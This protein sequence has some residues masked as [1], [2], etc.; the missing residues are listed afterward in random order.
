MEITWLGHSCVRIR[1]NDVTLITDPFDESLGLS[2]GAQSADIVTVSHLHPHH[3]THA[4]IQGSPRVL[5]GPG[6]YEI[7]NYYIT[8]IGTD[9]DAPQGEQTINTMYAI[10]CEGLRLCHLG[11]LN[12]GLSSRQIDYLSQTDV[13][14]VPAGGVCTLDTARVVELINLIAPRIVVPLH[15]RSDGVLVELQPLGPFLEAMGDARAASSARLTV[16]ATSLPRDL[17]LAVLDRSP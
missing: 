7:A 4:G 16:T 14:F 13:L 5:I 6:E 1:S 11:D 17:Q 8:G 12:Q 9:R 3:S 2:M 10:H 15:Y